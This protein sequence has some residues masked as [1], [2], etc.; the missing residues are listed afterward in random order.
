MCPHVQSLRFWILLLEISICSP[1]KQQEFW[2]SLI[3]P[4]QTFYSS[5][6]HLSWQ[7]VRLQPVSQRAV[8]GHWGQ[9]ASGCNRLQDRTAADE[10]AT[11]VGVVIT[12]NGNGKLPPPT[13]GQDLISEV[14]ISNAID[15]WIKVLQTITRSLYSS[16]Q[17]PSKGSRGGMGCSSGQMRPK[18]NHLYKFPWLSFGGWVPRTQDRGAKLQFTSFSFS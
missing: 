12:V 8:Q 3:A 17:W 16:Q 13:L 14:T 11:T 1:T 5:D 15:L 9:Y 6:Q 2:P 7:S 4:V 10:T 18:L